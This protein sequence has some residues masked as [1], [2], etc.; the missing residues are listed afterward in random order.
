[1]KTA[2]N[3]LAATVCS[4]MLPVMAGPVRGSEALLMSHSFVT[5][6]AA[7]HVVRQRAPT[8]AR[9]RDAAEMTFIVLGLVAYQLRRRHR[10]LQQLPRP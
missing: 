8:T 7:A 9:A 3:M 2:A 4:L 6:R 1:M 5:A 10:A